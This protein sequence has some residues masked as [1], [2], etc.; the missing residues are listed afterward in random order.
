[1]SIKSLTVAGKASEEYNNI[2]IKAELRPVVSSL[3]LASS[4]YTMKLQVIWHGSTRPCK[5][6]YWV[7]LCHIS[8][9]HTARYIRS[10][11][12]TLSRDTQSSSE[13]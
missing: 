10:T 5:K 11:S 4:L 3:A 9:C 12:A 1:M 7:L 2:L 13:R 6:L 8:G